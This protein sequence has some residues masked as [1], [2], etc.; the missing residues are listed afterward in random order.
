MNKLYY[1]LLIAIFLSCSNS[2]KLQIL[3]YNDPKLTVRQAMSFEQMYWTEAKYDSLEK[4]Y[5]WVQLKDNKFYN[6]SLKFRMIKVY[7]KQARYEKQFDEYNKIF[8]D[9]KEIKLELVPAFYFDVGMS[10]LDRA[11]LSLTNDTDSI[12]ANLI[13]QAIGY[14]KKCYLYSLVDKPE[15]QS[16]AVYYTGISYAMVGNF[17]LAYNEYKRAVETPIYFG[18]EYHKRSYFKLDNSRN[19]EDLPTTSDQ[20]LIY[21]NRLAEMVEEQKQINAGVQEEGK[22][23]SPEPVKVEEVKDDSQTQENKNDQR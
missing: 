3:N 22:I 21:K 18:S 17:E 2:D 5:K 7:G 6:D 9:E 8:D 1:A 4:L 23:I 20:D 14:F 15:I 13:Q 11:R 16:K 10:F 19:L 12:D